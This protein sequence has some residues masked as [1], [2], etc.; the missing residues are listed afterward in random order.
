MSAYLINKICYEVQRDETFREQVR[1]DPDGALK[2]M[3][4]TGDE[5]GAF[6]EGDIAGL[7]RMGGHP[8]LMQHL[9]R[10]KLFGLTRELH[11]ERIATVLEGA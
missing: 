9:W 5:I 10:A 3:G 6:K 4:L 2:G 1:K 8:F 11:F 7:Y